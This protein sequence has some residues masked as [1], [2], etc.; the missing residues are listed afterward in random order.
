MAT[1]TYT[2]Q[3]ASSEEM[4][5]LDGIPIPA[6]DSDEWLHPPPSKDGKPIDVDFRIGVERISEMNTARVSSSIRIAITYYWTDPRLAGWKEKKLPA[7]CWGPIF[8]LT[9]QLGNDMSIFDEVFALVDVKAGRIKRGV[10]YLGT[11]S[12][13]MDLTNFPWDSDTL[14]ILLHTTSH[15]KCFDGS[16]QNMLADGRAYNIRPVVNPAEGASKHDP[17]C[18]LEDEHSSKVPEWDLLGY[19]YDMESLKQVTGVESDNLVFR[20]LMARKTGYYIWKTLVPLYVITILNLLVFAFDATNMEARINH[21][22]VLVLTS[23]ATL[24]VINGELPKV[25]YLTTIDKVLIMTLC[26]NVVTALE[27][28]LIFKYEALRV[29]DDYI[30]WVLTFAFIVANFAVIVPARTKRTR[31]VQRVEKT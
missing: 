13:P 29:I 28:V 10:V 21:S 26:L 25:D 16:E 1:S 14:D 7:K 17:F 8:F 30:V 31:D 20:I 11:V 22:T 3:D 19:T 24:F 9:N 23:F 2:M 27:S 4:K 12:N 15:F 5:S 18:R 6:S